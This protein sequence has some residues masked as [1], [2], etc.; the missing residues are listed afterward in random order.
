[1]S[2][3]TVN[4]QKETPLCLASLNG[5][6][7]V[8]KMLIKEFQCNPF[9]DQ[10]LLHYASQ[11]KHLINSL[12]FEYGFSSISEDTDCKN[13]LHFAC[14]NGYTELIDVL[15]K[16][17]HLDPLAR[18][19]DGNTILHTASMCGQ[20]DMLRHILIK[21]YFEINSLNTRH[22]TSLDLAALYGH[23]NV[24]QTLFN[25]F[26]CS[27]HF[28]GYNGYTLLHFAS[29]GGQV[30][31]IIHLVAEYDLDPNAKDEDGNTPLHIAAMYGM[32]EVIECLIVERLVDINALNNEHFTPLFVAAQNGQFQAVK[33]LI[34]DFNCVPQS[35]DQSGRT[36]LHIAS[37]CGHVELIEALLTDFQLDHT[38]KDSD[39]NTALLLAVGKGHLEATRLLMMKYQNIDSIDKEAGG[40]VFYCA[41]KGGHNKLL[42]ILI[43]E[44][45]IGSVLSLDDD[46]NTPLHIS[47]IYKHWKCVKVLLYEHKAPLFVRNKLGKT[48]YDI[49]KTNQILPIVQIIEDYLQTDISLVQSTYQELERLAKQEFAGDEKHLTRVFVMGHSEAGK[50]TL[51]ETLKKE[52]GFSFGNLFGAGRSSNTVLPHTAGIVPSIHDANKDER[53]IFYDFAGDKEY[54]S[55]HAAILENIDTSE[56]VNLYLVVCDLSLDDDLIAKR[57]GY[58]LSFLLYTLQNVD[59]VSVILPVGSHADMLKDQMKVDAKTSILNQV[60]DQFSVAG[61]VHI[62]KG[63]AL[64]CRKKGNVVNQVKHL[65][66]KTSK[67]VPPVKLNPKTSLLLG[68]M[69]KSNVPACT[70]DKIIFHIKET[71]IPLP[72]RPLLLYPLIKELHNLG[73]V[74]VIEKEGSPIETHI[75]VSKVSSLTLDV[76]CKLFSKTGKNELAKYTDRLKLSVGIVPETLLVKVLPDYITKECLIK[77][78]YCQ[79]IENLLVGEDHTLTQSSQPTVKRG[80]NSLLFFPALCELTLED[81]QWPSVSDSGCALGWYAKC[82]DDRFDYFPTRFLHILIVRLSLKFAL[83]QTLPTSSDSP[84]CDTT[85]AELHA[86]NPRCHVWATGLHWLMKNGVE[87]FVDMPKDAESKE[88]VVVARSSAD[89]RAECANVLQ[90]VVQTVIEARVEFCHSILPSVYLLDPV[91]LKD[92]PFTKARNVPLYTLSDV[93]AALTEGSNMAVSVDGLHCSPPRDLTTLTRWTMSYWSKL[94]NASI[95]MIHVATTVQS[96]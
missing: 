46:G 45:Q 55:S 81:I 72:T 9:K 22:M 6:I 76:H 29:Q 33:F 28:K 88:L 26:N 30:E 58:W 27:P 16:N 95:I 87:V 67:S 4:H 47:T 32:N 82:T 65:A 37:E 91:K 19:D 18:D 17:Y 86:F 10:K 77:L 63:I 57:Y 71:E 75:I 34:N 21:Y 51:I 70:I 52:S 73:V 56:G 36:L 43:T 38:V 79:E 68:L 7:H 84:Q 49:A 89:Y 59:E 80:Q 13:L 5:H 60:S 35:R 92:E 44:Y 8:V 20:N 12:I 1:M 90:K 11:N 39:G 54:Y 74:L 31:V 66:R 61:N 24:L 3:N 85:L 96:S 42:S 48:A 78:Q 69:V 50:S 2:V 15:I 93:E 62:R 94:L 14:Q 83:K 41:C 64:D 23:Y 40:S 25:E 53:I